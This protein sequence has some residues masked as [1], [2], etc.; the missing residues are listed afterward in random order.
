[1]LIKNL[2][3]YALVYSTLIINAGNA[4]QKQEARDIAEQIIHQSIQELF[5]GIQLGNLEQIEDALKLGASANHDYT[6]TLQ[7]APSVFKQIHRTPLTLAIS[8]KN[9]LPV[10]QLLVQ[11]GADVNKPDGEG[12]IPIHIA[13]YNNQSDLV[14]FFIAHN[15]KVNTKDGFNRT[16]LYIA[17]DS[18]NIPLIAKILAAG[19]DVNL[20]AGPQNIS[21][22]QKAIL[23][24]NPE[25]VQLL[26]DHGVHTTGA[27][28]YALRNST[29][30]IAELIRQH[31]EK[32]AQSKID[33]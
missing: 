14:D 4:A 16:P 9:A 28:Q 3:L 29:S 8:Y 23:G 31:E 26:L 27:Y 10:A 7:L 22:L 21:P 24:K 11:Y 2:L 20:R 30:E 13:L 33:L 1:M 25:I 18:G 17:L 19:A 6:T 32:L 5:A 12:D 15:A